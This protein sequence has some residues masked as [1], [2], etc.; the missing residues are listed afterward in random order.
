MVILFASE[1][2]GKACNK[3]RWGVRR[4]GSERAG[5]V[6]RRL[7]DLY[8][9]DSLEDMRNVP[10]KCEELKRNRKGQ[11][12]VRLDGG[13]RLIFV[14]EHDPIPRKPDGGLDWKRVTAIKVIEVEDYHG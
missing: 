3:W 12:S 13:Y 8:A 9:A 14:P 2:L 11:L 4:W 1:Q 10:G 5:I 6:R 7:D